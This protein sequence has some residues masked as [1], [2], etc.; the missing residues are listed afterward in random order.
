MFSLRDQV[1]L[2]TGASRGL[3]RA[4][5][6]EYAR[7]GAH[8]VINSRASSAQAL[9]ETESIVRALNVPVLS[10]VADVSQR[11]DV[12]RLAGEALA[13]FGRVDTLVNN[14]S[15]L[16]PTPM[17]FLA[18]TPIEEFETVM[19]T[20]VT[21][22]FMLTR[23]LIGQML[24]RGAGS[25]INV[26]SDAGAVGYPTWGAYGVSKAALDHLTRVWAAELEG[27]GVRINSVD[28]GD[29]DTAM[30]RASEPDGDAAQWAKPETV[31]QVFVYLAS[32]ESVQIN[33]KRFLAQQF[34]I[35]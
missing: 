13:R 2:I 26:S 8:L 1:A 35:A 22:P 28:P 6:V 20:N 5:A 25:V 19:R 30:K 4:L 32:S 11:A 21:A 3:G 9:R 29:M 17:P 14:A 16:G 7:Q 31:T 24:S 33:G 10:V 27:T 15:A 34:A 23:A 12:E 18:D